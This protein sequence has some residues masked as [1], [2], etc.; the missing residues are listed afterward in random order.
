M[1]RALNDVDQDA[2][3]EFDVCVVGAGAAG[4]TLAHRL[5]STNLRVALLEAGGFERPEIGPEHPYRGENVGRR[6]SLTATRL[7]YF[8]GTTNHW[9]GWCRPLDDVDFKARPHIPLSGWPF[10]ADELVD[11][12][13]EA[14]RY[15]QIEPPGWE[16][17]WM[18][19]GGRRPEIFFG[20][21]DPDFV[22]KHFRFSPGTRFGEV[23]LPDLRDSQTT[24]CFVDST[25]A[26]IGLDNGRVAW[27]SVRG[28]EEKRYRV[29]ARAYVLAM[30]AIDNARLLLHSDGQLRH[31]VGN[32]SDWVGRCF[33][34]HPGWTIGRLQSRQPLPYVLYEKGG[35]RLLPHL[36]LRDEILE[37][38]GLVNFGLMC[39]PN[40]ARVP[41]PIDRAPTT[42]EP[43][44]IEDAL[45]LEAEIERADPRVARPGRQVPEWGHFHKVL[46]RLEAVPNRSSRITLT[47]DR[48]PYGVRRVRLDWRLDG[49]ELDTLDAI[50][51]LVGRRIGAHGLGR[52]QRLF[53]REEIERIN[54][55]YQSHH[56]GTTR[57]SSRPED[58]VVDADGR[59]HTVANLYMAGGSVFP[60]FGFTNPTLTI[61]ALAVRLADHLKATLAGS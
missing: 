21:H 37:Q 33:A 51:D 54:T 35:M 5:R 16:V 61:V 46:A 11:H 55:F 22:A 52:Y 28:P 56:M 39:L 23:Y 26:E 53:S 44:E 25:A 58:G 43:G 48:D 17:P 34:D 9:G 36:S 40:P 50:S 49:M 10:G 30:G 6:Y 7:R 24:H 1:L 13:R 57:M 4:I 60:T 29:R 14:G 19:H 15:C 20:H 59:V 42:G 45:D 32:E 47:R 31:G 3:V 18:P 2:T 27:L 38:N 8:G 12:Y 41:L